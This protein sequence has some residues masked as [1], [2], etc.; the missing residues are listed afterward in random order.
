[1][2]GIFGALD[3]ARKGLIVTQAGVR[4]AGHNIANANTPGYTQQRLLQAADFPIRTGVGLLGTGVISSGVQ[5]I[6][7]PFVQA[8][9]VRQRGAAASADAQAGVLSLVE[10]ILN[11]QDSG[12]ITAALGQF[13]DAIDDLA[14]S[15][16]PGAPAE[17]AALVAST[18]AVV[19]TI[20]GTDNR[21]RDLMTST[22]NGIEAII[23]RVNDIL[24]TINTLNGEITRTEINVATPAND[25][26]D[27][28]DGLLRELSGILDITYLESPNGSISVTMMSGAALVEGGRARTLG[29]VPD[30]ANP[31]SA[32]F[33]RIE[34]QDQSSTRNITAE[35]GAGELGGLL[36]ARDTILPGAIRSLDTVAYNLTTSVNAVHNAGQGLTGV[37]GDFFTSLPVVEDAARDLTIAANI[38]ANPDDIAAG[39][40]S[41]AGDN[42]N[43]LALAAL[44]DQK[45]PLFLPG[46]PPGPASGPSRSMIEHAVAVAVDVGQQAQSMTSSLMQQEKIVESL[47][48]RREEVS[49]VSIDE[50][51]TDLIKL[52]AAFQANS[53]VISVVQRLLDD[54]VNIL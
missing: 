51:V 17:R 10:E 31:F 24:A 14:T 48:D 37:T 50:Q 20:N 8:Q 7:D 52:Q 32:G 1:M 4:V 49:G 16:A 23:P 44:R 46:D 39:I 53:R 11:E 27:Q 29:T 41:A 13:Y 15:S 34:L 47:E 26:R 30:P 9:L 36:R 38:L 12:G 40:T 18:Q 33:V 42:Q 43:A 5:R 2:T 45:S 3:V 22:N 35:V 19:D 54:L 6:T 25:L 28:R 21:L